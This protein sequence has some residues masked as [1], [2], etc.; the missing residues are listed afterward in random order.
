MS[1]ERIAALACLAMYL[2]AIHL[3]GG[4]IAFAGAVGF[5]IAFVVYALVIY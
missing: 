5:V 4:T 1:R 3:F 2:S